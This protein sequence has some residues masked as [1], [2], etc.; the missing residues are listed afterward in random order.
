MLKFKL[1]QWATVVFIFIGLLSSP[2]TKASSQ[3]S[4]F[5]K[6]MFDPRI[7]L[8]YLIDVTAMAGSYSNCQPLNTV[9]LQKAMKHFGQ[10]DAHPAV[11]FYREKIRYVYSNKVLEDSFLLLPDTFH[12]EDIFEMENLPKEITEF[13]NLAISFYRDTRVDQ[14][15][16]SQQETLDFI[17]K[18]FQSM[19]N[20]QSWQSIYQEWFSDSME[21]VC[22]ILAPLKTTPHHA[23]LSGSK[24]K[25][26]YVLVLGL[27]SINNGFLVFATAS[28]IQESVMVQG[29][30]HLFLNEM[31]KHKDQSDLINTLMQPYE[32]QWKSMNLDN[33]FQYLAFH[34]GN[35][36]YCKLMESYQD[37]FNADTYLN[38]TYEKGYV[39]IKDHS[40]L[41]DDF[42]LH[43]DV[44][45]DFN[46][47]V[48]VWMESMIE[49]LTPQL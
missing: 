29:S 3:T 28:E 38:E 12:Q 32:E 13:L 48:P 6:A 43:R 45:L 23:K 27:S 11:T 9:Y 1:S 19:L 31:D 39:L 7:E 8:L 5:L 14:F 47:F 33:P 36:I 44:Y 20:R 24:T 16:L 4:P 49:L 35:S 18:S 10:Y 26:S 17:K 30:A 25:K 2:L 15:L 22:M 21:E 46:S 34:M 40:R 37:N 41:L 42:I